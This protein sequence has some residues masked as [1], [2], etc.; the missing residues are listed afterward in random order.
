[1]SVKG[2]L[3]V[4]VQICAMVSCKRIRLQNFMLTMLWLRACTHEDELNNNIY[5]FLKLPYPNFVIIVGKTKNNYELTV[6]QLNLLT[7]PIKKIN[8][9]IMPK[10]RHCL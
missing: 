8:I 6:K 4:F 9:L 2:P 10:Q 5:S 7:W 3:E 1:M